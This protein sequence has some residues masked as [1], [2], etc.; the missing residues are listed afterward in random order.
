[1]RDTYKVELIELCYQEEPC[2][3]EWMEEGAIDQDSEHWKKTVDTG[4]K[5]KDT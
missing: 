5:I 2:S 1:M 4:L 3:L